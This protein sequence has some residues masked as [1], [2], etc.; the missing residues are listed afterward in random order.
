MVVS[1]D[2]GNKM[3]DNTLNILNQQ[4]LNF[5][6]NNQQFVTF[7][8]GD[9]EYGIDVMLVQEITRYHSPT[10]VFNSN[11]VINGLINFR[12]KVIP[13][14]DLR[15]KFNLEEREYDKFTVVIV[16]EVNGKTMG[17]IVDRISDIVSFKEEDIQIVDKEMADDIKTEHLK[18]MAKLDDKII[19][20]LD[21]ERVISFEEIEQLESDNSNSVQSENL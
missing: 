7:N 16:I 4:L 14:I 17:F 5:T 10:K 9:E 15:K 20:L 6:D 19:M 11:P 1:D 21:P 12:G 3:E 18:G 8:V 2:S 13:Q